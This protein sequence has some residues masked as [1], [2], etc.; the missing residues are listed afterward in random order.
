MS[1]DDTS[2]GPRGRRWRR[3]AAVRP[4]V[5]PAQGRP[6][7]QG[8]GGG[9]CGMKGRGEAVGRLPAPTPAGARPAA[10]TRDRWRG[11]QRGTTRNRWRGRSDRSDRG[12]RPRIVAARP[13]TA[14]VAAGL[15]PAEGRA[16]RA[17][18]H[19]VCPGR[20]ALALSERSGSDGR[21]ARDP[22]HQPKCT[23][24][25]RPPHN[26]PAPGLRTARAGGRG[27]SRR[28]ARGPGGRAPAR[29][30][31]GPASRGSGRSPGRARGLR[32]ARGRRR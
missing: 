7:Q 9:G 15:A 28:R 16:T 24:C 10:T 13:P 32:P 29:R 30:R 12:T 8:I 31:G 26:L 21:P 14:I 4:P 18:S 5:R 17:T 23:S 2:C 11:R 22:S 19:R 20:S 25:V 1:Q 3:S 6:L 27:R